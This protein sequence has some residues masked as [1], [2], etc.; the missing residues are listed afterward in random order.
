MVVSP[1]ME[2][3]RKHKVGERVCFYAIG[4]AKAL[5]ACQESELRAQ[6]LDYQH[7]RETQPINSDMDTMSELLV[8]AGR[9]QDQR[10][11]LPH[12]PLP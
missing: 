6:L 1:Q 5:V 2:H 3:L 7:G 12:L 4:N 8:P 9:D 11:G 10:E